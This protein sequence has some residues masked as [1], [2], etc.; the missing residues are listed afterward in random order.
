MPRDTVQPLEYDHKAAR[1]RRL[2]TA[3][4]ALTAV[5]CTAAVSLCLVVL[6]HPASAAEVVRALPK[7]PPTSAWPAAGQA[8][9]AVA[10]GGE[11]ASPG[12][13]PVPTASTAKLMTAYVFLS[14]HPLEPGQ[15]GPSFTVSA[16]EAARYPAR[17]AQSESVVPLRP[18]QRMTER[19][20][21]QALLAAS[22]NNVADELAR[23]YG[24]DPVA[25]VA[26][27]N[28]TARRLGMD[29][30]HYT[31]PSGLHTTSIT[32]AADQVRLLQAALR[33]PD[34]ATLAGSSYTDTD[35][36][37]HPNT[38][39]LL[40]RD[41]VFAGKTG[42]TRAAGRNLV[43]AARRDTTDGSRVIVGAVLH[44]PDTAALKTATRRLI[45]DSLV[46]APVVRKGETLAWAHDGWG[47]SVALR[48]EHDLRVTG[49][50]GSNAVLAIEP[51]PAPA[52]GAPAGTTAARVAVLRLQPTDGG[53]TTASR[54][55]AVP[56]PSV[57]DRQGA[58]AGVAL[59]SEAPLPRTPPLMWF[60]LR[61]LAWLAQAVSP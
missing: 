34:F 48:A 8:A 41:G 15:A 53:S 33:L 29:A 28:H 55:S 9:L 35:G 10:G 31:D 46:T 45:A 16:G 42:T 5:V 22:A 20:A 4:P 43:F 2:L 25:F 13:A 26:E 3:L 18:G 23:W 38:N 19:Q 54:A 36:H 21:L 1:R 51:A 57:G 59:Q 24:S 61:P 60:P 27:M 56:A 40:G 12:Q 6:G 52:V 11:Y 49:P 32:T 50:P 14:R 30:T 44:Q 58:R 47:R 7:A 17:L 37:H 39:P